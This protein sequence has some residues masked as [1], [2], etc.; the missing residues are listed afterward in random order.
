MKVWVDITN[1]PHA[2]FFKG[3]IRELEKSGYEIIITTREFDGLTGILD[4]LG[5]DYYVVG[6][7]G[8]ATLEGK[9]LASSER[10]YKLSKLIIEEKPDLAIYKH[11]AEAPRVAFGLQVPSIG[12]ID[13]ETAI[14]QNKLI[15]PFTKLLLYPRAI[16]A[17]E[18]IKCGA[19]PNGMRPVNGFSE[20]AHLYGFKP[21]RKVLK[22]LG[23]K[24]NG[25]IVMRTEPI[26][27]NYFN[28][29]IKSILEDVIPLL[30]D[31]PIVL[32]PRTEEQRKRFERFDNVIMP[33][34]PVDSLSL[35]YYARLMI[36]AG[37][38]MNREAIALGTPTI[39]TYPGK[40]LAVTKWLVELGVKFHSTDP[41]EVATVAERM[42][43]MNGSYRNYIRSVVSGL[44]NPME[45]ILK[46]IETYETEG[47][48]LVSSEAGNVGSYVSLDKRSD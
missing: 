46:E 17:Y 38:T 31:I 18:L 22:E 20:L 47:T 21:E 39:S 6:K 28:G 1:A 12:F 14:G 13:N 11:S 35:L 40:L 2:H 36:G 25:Y 9:L 29:D 34:K 30:P 43:E 41:L 15:A 42:I 27:A 23:V 32:F 33:E 44:E 24:R 16:D 48:F 45:V 10:V 5:F 37:G 26:K 8:G 3:L 19:D 7:H 4:M